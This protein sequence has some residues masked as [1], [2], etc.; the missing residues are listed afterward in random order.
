MNFSGSSFL[1]NLKWPLTLPRPDPES[2][3][4]AIHSDIETPPE[5]KMSM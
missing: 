2:S 4:E 1:K 3:K 5:F